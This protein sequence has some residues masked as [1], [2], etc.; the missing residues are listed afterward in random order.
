VTDEPTIYEADVEPG[1]PHNDQMAARARDDLDWHVA[2]AAKPL[3]DG[4][5]DV[6]A[7][8]V[9]AMALI[10]NEAVYPHD[11]L[12]SLLAV[13]LVRLAKGDLS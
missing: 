10:D 8:A 5:S 9:I 13:A 11:R 6:D 3:A 12:A 1:D 2:S 4:V 7:T